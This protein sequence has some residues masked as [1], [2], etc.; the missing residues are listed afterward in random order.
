MLLYGIAV[1]NV[2]MPIF[3][4]IPNT[5]IVNATVNDE[6]IGRIMYL[7]TPVLISGH[8]LHFFFEFYPTQDE[9]FF[10]EA[11]KAHD[12]I[13]KSWVDYAVSQRVG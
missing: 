8:K 3:K 6:V 1:M 5:L 4:Q 11:N 12:Y 13:N 10:R 7:N 9:G 2:V